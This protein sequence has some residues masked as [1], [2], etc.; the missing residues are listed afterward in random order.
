MDSMG[1]LR[2]LAACSA[3]SLTLISA[4]AE[5]LAAKSARAKEL[6]AAGRFEEAIPIYRELVKAIPGNPGPIMNLGLALHMAGQEREAIRQFHVVLRLE[7]NHL[8]AHLFL[9]AAYLGFKEPAQAIEPLKTVIQAKPNDKEAR[10]MLGEAFLSL[11]FFQSATEQFERLSELDPENPK[12]WNGLGLSY[13]G[14]A[15][16]NF[17]QLEKIA[18]GSPYWRVLVAEARATVGLYTRAFLLYREA[19]AKMPTM[20]GI[21][22]AV[23]EIYRRI[24]QPDWA[25][26][27]EEKERKLPAL[28]CGGSDAASLAALATS[29]KNAVA[30]SGREGRFLGRKLECE[31]WAGRYEQVIASS[32]AGRTAEAYFWRTRAYNELARRAFSRLAQLPPSAEV[33]ELLGTIHFNRKKYSE[34]AKEWEEALKF[35]PGNWYYRERLAISL[36]SSHDYEGARRL[37]EDL[38]MRSPNSAELNYWLGFT[39]LGLLEADKALPFLEKAVVA[40]STVLAAHRELARA[41]LQLGKDEKAVPHLKAALPADEDGSLYYQLARAYRNVGQLELAKEMLKKFR[42]IEAPAA[43]GKKIPERESE[44]TPP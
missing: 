15:S 17:V 6:M 33:H 31:F 37:L 10:L 16:R 25:A 44:I 24:S 43:A 9:G 42:E 23:A 7:P 36:S 4:R 8:P 13:E 35:A 11:E 22:T 21:H 32:K 18:L 20:R 19:Q 30:S 3:L 41:Y 1:L 12:V 34:S 14:L 29:P 2:V 5:D 38:I 28:D 39:L 26:I 40:D 27:E